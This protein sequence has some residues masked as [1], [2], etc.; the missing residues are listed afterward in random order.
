MTA[1][2]VEDRDTKHNRIAKSRAGRRQAPSPVV[3]VRRRYTGAAGASI[4]DLPDREAF[5]R[6]SRVTK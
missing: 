4:G 1:K 6:G 5:D 2:D 3:I